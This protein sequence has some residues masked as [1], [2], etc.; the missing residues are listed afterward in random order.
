M[1]DREVTHAD[2]IGEIRSLRAEY[3]E[4]QKRQDDIMSRHAGH[5]AE[6]A[7][8][9]KGLDRDVAV[10]MDRMRTYDTLTDRVRSIENRQAWWAGAAAVAGAGLAQLWRKLMGG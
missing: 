10:L 6:M 2:I 3:Q 9:I 8:S 7:E 4:A 5:L 1:A